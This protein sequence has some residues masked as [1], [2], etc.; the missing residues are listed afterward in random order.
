LTKNVADS[1]L[2]LLPKDALVLQLPAIPRAFLFMK[3]NTYYFSHDYNAANDTKILFLRHQLGMEGYGIYWYLIEQLA[4]AGG[5]LPLELI[6]VL[7]MQMHCTDVKVNGV[8]MNFGLF[9]ILSGEF[10]SERL[11]HHLELRLKLSESGKTGANNRWGNRVAIGEANAKESKVKEIKE[12]EIKVNK[13]NIIDSA[14]NEWWDSYDKKIS[15]DKAIA[16]WNILTNEEKQLALKIV[17]EYVN[18]TPDK[19]FRKD[20]TTYLNNKSF[21]DEIIIRS[22]TTSHKPN[23]SERNFTKLA[24]LKYIEP[25]RD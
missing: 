10:W 17:Q 13:I 15:K 18:S 16:K 2:N 3:S 22:S 1:I 7:A 14:F 21:N 4:N 19:T 9:T 8:L 24:S 23:V 5:K 25:K 11:A 12:K 6:P 20:P